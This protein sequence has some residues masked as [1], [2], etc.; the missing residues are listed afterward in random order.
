MVLFYQYIWMHT[1]RHRREE[2]QINSSSQLIKCIVCQ[3]I[4]K[5]L[6]ILSHVEE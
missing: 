3:R 6:L 5:L 4:A 1:Y 2:F